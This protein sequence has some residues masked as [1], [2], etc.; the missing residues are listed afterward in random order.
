LVAITTDKGAAVTGSAIGE[1][2]DTLGF[3]IWLHK[4]EVIRALE[5]EIDAESDDANALTQEQRVSA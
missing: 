3:M 4:E 1:M 2:S 5:A